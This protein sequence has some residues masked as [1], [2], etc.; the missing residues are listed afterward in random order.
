MNNFLYSPL[1]S[2]TPQLCSFTHK[3]RIWT[4]A[5]KKGV[6]FCKKNCFCH[7]SVNF[8]SRELKFSASRIFTQETLSLKDIR[9]WLR[10]REGIR[11]LK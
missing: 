6:K 5:Q 2:F 7:N 11:D 3:S 10:G 8:W 4:T 9:D 1:T